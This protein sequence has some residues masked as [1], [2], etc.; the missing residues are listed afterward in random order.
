M[1]LYWISLDYARTS[2][3]PGNPGRTGPHSKL[4][5]R[6]DIGGPIMF[7]R[8]FEKILEL[9]IV[10]KRTRP[11]SCPSKAIDIPKASRGPCSTPY[12]PKPGP[13]AIPLTILISP[14]QLHSEAQHHPGTWKIA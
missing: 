8:Y 2:N 14:S 12:Y 10:S 9:S 7:F 13:I 4:T 11:Q 3:E 5:L 1:I 6:L